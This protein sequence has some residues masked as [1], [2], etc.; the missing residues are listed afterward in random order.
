MSKKPKAADCLKA[1]MEIHA[2]GLGSEDMEFD[3]NAAGLEEAAASA[4]KALFGILA[5]VDGVFKTVDTQSSFDKKADEVFTFIMS[6][7]QLAF[8]SNARV[9]DELE[10]AGILSPIGKPWTPTNVSKIMVPV[11]ERI[12]TS[13]SG[14]V[15]TA[16]PVETIKVAIEAKAKIEA[17]AEAEAEA[18]PSEL[19][20]AFEALSAIDNER[21][22]TACEVQPPQDTE[23][24]EEAA[25]EAAEEIAK[26]I[27]EE[28][29]EETEETDDLIA[30]LEKLEDVA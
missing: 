1:I 25:E 14:S 9:A 6:R 3:V 18:K 29:A 23:T 15:S 28:T 20:Q 8:E 30:E 26:G 5:V 11:R 4:F 21:A 16:S 19:T 22:K 24:A 12:V 10:K 7:F 13:M 2:M 17:K 27:A